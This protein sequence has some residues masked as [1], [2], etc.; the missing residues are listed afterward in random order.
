MSLKC[1]LDLANIILPNYVENQLYRIIQETLSNILRHSKA[2][3]VNIKLESPGKGH[4]ANLSIE[5]NGIG[6]DQSKIPKTSY[7]IKSIRERV[8]ELGGTVKWIS[9]PGKG[10]KIEVRVPIRREEL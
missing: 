6:F 3:Q 8:N 4:R 9:L 1:Y 5:D 7:G 2:S 10:T